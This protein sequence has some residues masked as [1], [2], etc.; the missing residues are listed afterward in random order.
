MSKKNSKTKGSQSERIAV[1]FLLEKGYQILEKN[2]RCSKKEID[3]IAK[4]DNVISF[5]EVKSKNENV[6]FNLEYSITAS[7][8]KN[9][10]EV[11]NYYVEK[12]NLEKHSSIDTEFSFDVIF[13][14]FIKGEIEIEHFENSFQYY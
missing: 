11:A 4:K 13:V 5:I 6:N 9:I 3:I 7:K 14:K 1:D 8:Q 2:F 10:F 12:H